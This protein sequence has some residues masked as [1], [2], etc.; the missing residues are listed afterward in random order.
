VGC[1]TAGWVLTFGHAS[2]VGVTYWGKRPSGQDRQD[3]KNDALKNQKKLDANFNASGMSFP[4]IPPVQP[5]L[6]VLPIPPASADK[7]KR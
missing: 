5:I 4:P 7:L 6:P 3:G 1:F 2:L